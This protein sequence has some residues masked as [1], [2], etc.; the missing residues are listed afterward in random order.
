MS[1]E[2]ENTA[3]SV[4]N[5]QS[6]ETNVE[7]IVVDSMKDLNKERKAEK[8]KSPDDPAEELVG[9][10]GFVNKGTLGS[11]REN[12]SPSCVDKVNACDIKDPTTT[13]A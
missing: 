9:G 11:P 7:T 13:K 4:Q 2:D 6:R 8:E 12:E 10:D 5:E 1:V 3:F